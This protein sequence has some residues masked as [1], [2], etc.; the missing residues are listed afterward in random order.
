MIKN[1]LKGLLVLCFILPT[2]SVFIQAQEIAKEDKQTNSGIHII[3]LTSGWYNP[4][5]NFWNNYFKENQWS[6]RFQ[7]S[8]YY[9]GFFQL[10]SSKI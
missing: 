5:M 10:K 2:T 6:N 8:M 3:C 1:T 7:G 9:G 4:A